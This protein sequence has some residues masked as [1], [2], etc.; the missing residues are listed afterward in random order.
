MTD[1]APNHA[2]Q[3]TASAR[4]RTSAKPIQRLGRDSEARLWSIRRRR[5][6]AHAGDVGFRINPDP[7]QGDSE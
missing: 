7:F 4:H 3:L 6:P 2:M 5:C 1:E